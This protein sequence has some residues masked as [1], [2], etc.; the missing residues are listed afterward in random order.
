MEKARS[1]TPFGVTHIIKEFCFVLLAASFTFQSA[2]IAD[3]LAPMSTLSH[4]SDVKVDTAASPTEVQAGEVRAKRAHFASVRPSSKAR[5]MAD[6]V[7]VSRDNGSMPFAIVD[8]EDAKVF[9]F[10]A[11]GRLRGTTPVL[12]GL[13]VGDDAVPGIGDRPLSSIRDDER[14]TPA[15]RFV[16]ELDRNLRGKEILW[17]DYDGAVSM[18]PVVSTSSRERRLERL[19]SPSPL[20]NRISYG[21]INVP[22]KFFADVIR[23]AFKGTNGIVYV[24]PETKP[25]NEVFESYTEARND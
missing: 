7:V 5:N 6:W 1:S 24:L 19:A 9:V 23:P 21:C 3:A 8:K 14:T 17:V 25:L 10:N 11:D 18:H 22:T 16:A 20:D 2:A 12:L 15:G 4:L 13:A